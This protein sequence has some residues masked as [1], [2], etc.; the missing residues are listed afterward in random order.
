MGLRRSRLIPNIN[1]L[2]LQLHLRGGSGNKRG[3]GGGANN[4]NTAD[5][6]ITTCTKSSTKVLQDNN[7]HVRGRVS[8]G[9]CDVRSY[10]Q[11]LGDHPCCLE[12]CPIQLGWNYQEEISVEIDVYENS[13]QQ[14]Q[15]TIINGG[16]SCEMRL[17]PEERKS[18]LFKQFPSSSASA[19]SASSSAS[20]TCSSSS[21]LEEDDSEHSHESSSSSSSQASH[22]SHADERELLRECR[23]LNRC[24]RNSCRKRIRRNQK[25]F[26]GTT[27]S[28]ATC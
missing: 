25:E 11:V 3:D 17:S 4:I 2:L 12:G 20:S 24:G 14:Q 27:A 26:F 7:D 5:T 23:K 10:T 15:Q 6:H 16:G 9:N 21:D 28:T 18:I 19:S 1:S 8:F 13:K 22:A